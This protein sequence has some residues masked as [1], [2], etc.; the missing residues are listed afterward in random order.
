MGWVLIDH[1]EHGVGGVPPSLPFKGTFALLHRWVDQ[2]QR[3]VHV[4]KDLEEGGP[5]AYRRFSTRNTECENLSMGSDSVGHPNVR[6]VYSICARRPLRRRVLRSDFGLSN[7]WHRCI[8]NT[9]SLHGIRNTVLGRSVGWNGI[10]PSGGGVIL[11]GLNIILCCWPSCPR[12]GL[13][14]CC[15][16][17]R[18]RSCHA[19]EGKAVG[20]VDDCASCGRGDEFQEVCI[21][22]IP[23]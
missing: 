18:E 10:C 2:P 13:Q 19:S 23:A 12:D 1:D 14:T 16:R 4:S 15:D 20:E 22:H 9:G 6:L 11:R 5:E 17:C 7:W 21:L 8:T 3:P